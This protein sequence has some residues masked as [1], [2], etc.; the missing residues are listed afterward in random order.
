[1][2]EDDEHTQNN[3]A[4]ISI[5][6]VPKEHCEVDDLI[7]TQKESAVGSIHDLFVNYRSSMANRRYN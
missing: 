1:M 3:E 7:I 6:P 5:E 2:P 4:F